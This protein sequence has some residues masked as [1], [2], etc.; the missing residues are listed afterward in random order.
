M[1]YAWSCSPPLVLFHPLC[2][3]LATEPTEW[4]G[5]RSIRPAERAPFWGVGACRMVHRDTA[6]CCEA[7]KSARHPPEPH[8]Q[9]AGT[10]RPRPAR[11][12]RLDGQAAIPRCNNVTAPAMQRSA[13]SSMALDPQSRR[14]IPP[15]KRPSSTAPDRPRTGRLR[16]R[17]SSGP[18]LSR[19][20]SFAP[21][22]GEA[23]ERQEFGV[24]SSVG[25]S[26]TR[27]EGPSMWMVTQWCWSRSRRASTRGF[28]PKRGYQSGWLML[29]VRSVEVRA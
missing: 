19:C 23:A 10:H 27:R 25:A 3:R 22:C 16:F 11:L 6:R 20:S 29:V 5:R 9:R 4:G 12:H 14:A 17:H 8:A 24:S 2:Y 15:P 26:G 18:C 13:S 1:G 7:P 21:R 28:R